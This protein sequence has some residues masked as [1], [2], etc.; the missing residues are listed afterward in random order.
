M[1]LDK[2]MQ[3]DCDVVREA[4]LDHSF[5]DVYLEFWEAEKEL[6]NMK[7]QLDQLNIEQSNIE[8]IYA[9]SSTWTLKTKIIQ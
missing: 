4:E 7:L 9:L 3:T 1:K 8:G 6:E 5:R 2:T